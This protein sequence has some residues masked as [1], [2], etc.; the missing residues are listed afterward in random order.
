MSFSTRRGRPAKPK[1]VHDTGTPELQ[2]K[3]SVGL[4]MEAI[5]AC[6]ERELITR[7]QHWAGL[8]YRWL[9][10]VRYGAPS[11]SSH[12]WR[13]TEQARGPRTDNIDWRTAR[14]QEYAEARNLLMMHRLYE[15]VMQIAVY[16]ETPC[17]LRPDLLQQALARPALLARIESESAL[18][19]RGLELLATHWRRTDR[20][21]PHEIV[22]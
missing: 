10:T 19:I 6:L 9:Y 4:T 15:S 13:L 12:W 18:F 2:A 1:I 3:K 14:E 16:N 8:H 17:F 22:P 11:I 5:D 7:E 21:K 20:A